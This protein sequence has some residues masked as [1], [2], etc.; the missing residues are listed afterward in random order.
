MSL[1]YTT[2][3]EDYTRTFDS[4]RNQFVISSTNASQPNFRFYI[5]VY[6][7]NSGYT[8]SKAATIRKRP[9]ANGTCYFNPSEIISNYI[10][11]DFEVS[12][13]TI[14][15][16]TNSNRY[17]KLKTYEEY[18]TPGVIVGSGLESA[19]KVIYNGLQQY[20]PYDIMDYNYGNQQWV[21]RQGSITGSTGAYTGGTG[22]YLTD[23][24][25]FNVDTDEYNFLYFLTSGTTRPTTELITVYY[26]YTEPVYT[27]TIT[28][29]PTTGGT[30]IGSGVYEYGEIAT[31]SA[32]PASGYTFWRWTYTEGIYSVATYTN[33]LNLTITHD[34]PDIVANF[35]YTP[36]YYTVS[37]SATNGG[38]VTGAGQYISGSVCTLVASNNAQWA[39]FTG[40][41]LDSS[42]G[43][44]LSTNP[45]YYFSVTGNTTLVATFVI[46]V[47]MYIT[48]TTS[49]TPPIGLTSPTIQQRLPGVGTTT[50]TADANYGIYTFDHWTTGGINVSTDATYTFTT[51]S[52]NTHY[53]AVYSH[54]A[55]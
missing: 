38:T 6:I 3:P 9:L 48:I 8:Y 51:P 29:S 13:L 35:S 12:A 16:A 24:I 7:S 50:I 32:T 11:S 17:F 39:I 5:E 10:T 25:N 44:T 27:V 30:T 2:Q 40:W 31:L 46:S 18:G 41:H 28:E 21:M 49:S 47:P 45:T 14:S 43:T 23:A 20:I 55:E 26:D 36:T 52:V 53:I 1:S 4:N 34:Y 15:G 42:T 54:T 37:A 22:S 19:I 33:P